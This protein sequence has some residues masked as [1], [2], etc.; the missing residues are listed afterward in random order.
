MSAKYIASLFKKLET[1]AKAADALYRKSRQAALAIYRKIQSQRKWVK[2][3]INSLKKSADS[4]LLKSAQTLQQILQ[5]AN[6]KPQAPVKRVVPVIQRAVPKS[7]VRVNVRKA[8]RRRLGILVSQTMEQ[9]LLNQIFHASAPARNLPMLNKQ[10]LIANVAK[11]RQSAANAAN[12][13]N[14]ALSQLKVRQDNDIGK[15]GLSGPSSNLTTATASGVYNVKRANTVLGKLLQMWT[16]AK[17][18]MAK[19]RAIR[20]RIEKEIAV[21]RTVTANYLS[22]ISKGMTHIA[23]QKVAVAGRPVAQ[24]AAKVRV[25]RRPTVQPLRPV[26]VQRVVKKVV[27]AP[28]KVVVKVKLSKK[29]KKAAEKKK[30]KVEKKKKE[31]KKK[32]DK[33]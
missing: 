2:G 1:R 13:A 14:Q 33:K 9:K 11:T 15:P 7:T 4:N 18:G 28:K 3:G 8:P 32:A 6:V 26:V 29:A 10:Q 16:M 25:I 19:A 22:M 12:R 5:Q 23:P 31:A 17:N 20:L 21:A 24:V 30:K 27:A